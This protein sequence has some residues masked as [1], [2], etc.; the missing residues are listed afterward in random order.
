MSTETV[1]LTSAV[2]S[3][4]HSTLDVKADVEMTPSAS[5]EISRMFNLAW[6]VFLA[7]QL[8]TLPGPICVA[9]VGHIQGNNTSVL[10]DAAYLSATMTNIT[11]LAIGFGL[12][13]AMDT[14]CSQAFG[15]GKMD[16]LGV[17]LQSGVLVLGACLLPVFYMSWE[18]ESIMLFF[19]QD[20]EISKYAG[21]FSRVT[22]WG[23]PFLFVYELIKKLQQSQN[24]VLPMMYVAAIGVVVNLLTGYYFTYHTSWGFLGA[25]AGRVCGNIALPLSIVIYFYFDHK[26]TS[27][28]WNGFQWREAADHVWL[29]LSLGIP[30]MMMLAVSWWAFCTLG[31]LAGLLPN[32]IEAVSVNAVLGQLL[33]LNFMIYLGISVS[34]N[35][36]IGNALGANQP[37]RAQ[38]I[39][40]LALYGGY[41]SAVFMGTIF[42]IFRHTIPIFFVSDAAT[43]ENVANAMFVMIP[44]GVFDGLNGICEG[45]FKGMGR[46]TV[47][48]VINILSYYA[49]GL[50]MAYLVGFAWKY[51][52]EGVW[53]GFS[54]GTTLCFFVFIT[55]I[56]FTNWPELARL[57]Q[58]R[59]QM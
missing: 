25:A 58:E 17:Y 13:S 7:Y 6:P 42:M 35:V 50:P 31:F 38:L 9:L 44:L 52:L 29:F 2:D 12:A 59:V 8:E 5:V 43:I 24:I 30:S 11:A 27:T 28:W 23:I 49:F 4:D 10:V 41:A 56:H 22:V 3:A 14:L 36:L 19:G 20:P 55:M 51:G 37:L 45:I 48:A 39:T 16:K 46:Q 18:A 53:L 34:S 57:A 15:A 54:S 33:T 40:R 26:T 32:N 1:P 47:A 21:E